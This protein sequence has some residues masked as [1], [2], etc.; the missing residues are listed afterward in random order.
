M[1]ETREYLLELHDVR[2][3]LLERE[4]YPVPSW[5]R[6]TTI[7][8]T[9]KILDGEWFQL[10]KFRE[11]FKKMGGKIRIRNR[12]SVFQG[13]EW[14]MKETSFYNQ[15]TVSYRD[16]YSTK[17]IKLFPNGSIQAAGCSDLLDCHRVLS[18][19]SVLLQRVFDLKEK[20][21]LAQPTVQMIN[22]NF[23]LNS[24]VNLKK[25]IDK[26]SSD[27]R[28]MVTFDPEKYSAVKIKFEPCD[29]MKKVTA[30]IFSTGKVIVTGA[31]SLKEIVAAYKIINT[32]IARNEL[33]QKTDKLETFD[34]FMGSKIEDL[35]HKLKC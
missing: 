2:Q 19:L 4:D 29:G 16:A 9:S 5:V 18:M 24:S 11:T 23:S 34:V 1:N 30:S 6:I 27:K 35:I 20:P 25:V 10:H 32:V 17:S 7:T 26:F 21:T 3:H 12:N 15:V 13:F 28:F 33:V 31:R 14:S 22:T 8:M